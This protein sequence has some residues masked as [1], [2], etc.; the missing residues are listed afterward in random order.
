MPRARKVA[1][2]RA[3]VVGYLRYIVIRDLY[4]KYHQVIRL[5][6]TTQ[7]RSLTDTSS[8]VGMRKA[9]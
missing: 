4:F 3:S 9:C 5:Y 8:A 2:V 6:N 1:A 7:Y